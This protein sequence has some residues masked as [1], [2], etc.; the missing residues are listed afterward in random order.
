MSED[1][2]ILPNKTVGEISDYGADFVNLL[3]SGVTITAAPT[4]TI[5]VISGEDAAAGSMVSGAALVNGTQVSQRIINGVDGVTYCLV[6]KATLSD[7]QERH[8]TAHFTVED[9]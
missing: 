9:C 5:S 4:S 1:V 3:P 8:I 2:L 6:F 7:G